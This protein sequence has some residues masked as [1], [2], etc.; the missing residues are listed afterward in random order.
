MSKRRPVRV[1]H[2]RVE[3]YG[4]GRRPRSKQWSWWLIG[5]GVLAVF[6]FLKTPVLSLL[7]CAGVVWYWRS[8]NGRRR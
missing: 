1:V 3:Y 2:T 6:L 8:Q 5:G 4:Y 7:M